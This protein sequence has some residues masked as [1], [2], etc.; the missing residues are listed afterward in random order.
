[1]GNEQCNA[2]VATHA[3]AWNKKLPF[4]QFP[5]PQFPIPHY[6]GLP[7]TVKAAQNLG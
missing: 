7:I 1:M 3:L 4:S 2:G 6:Q 5:I